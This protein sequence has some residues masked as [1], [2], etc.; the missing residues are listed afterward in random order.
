MNIND[1]PRLFEPG[2]CEISPKA[3][4][5]EEFEGEPTP[6]NIKKYNLQRK[7]FLDGLHKGF[8]FK[9][10]EQERFYYQNGAYQGEGIIYRPAN[11]KD[12]KL[13]VVLYYHGGGWMKLCKECYE[14]ECAALAEQ[15]GCA[16]LNVD[17][18]C[19]PEYCFPVPLND[20]YA[21]LEEIV[22]RADDY[23]V[24]RER[25]ALAG[26]SAGGNLA[27]GVSMMARKSPKIS[28]RFLGLAYPAV[29]ASRDL[30]E[31]YEL[32]SEYAGNEENLKN[33]LVSPLF[34]KEPEKLPPIL[35]LIGSCDFLLDQN[36]RYARL[37]MQQGGN[38]E[39]KLYQGM[40][41]GFL[42][43]TIPHGEDALALL[44]NRISRYLKME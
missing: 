23:G 38:V 20:C 33:P 15:T 10:V 22:K 42:Q 36:L 1:Y 37:V 7:R 25:V 40:P 4:K 39:L 12:E 8:S 30:Y 34:D 31:T 3:Q 18:R 16:V 27:I 24:D 44:S 9:K 29:A 26:D 41:H 5:F 32:M 43:M 6:E 11:R 21:A 14:Y 28:I 35:I 2:F 13:P 17:Y 19:L